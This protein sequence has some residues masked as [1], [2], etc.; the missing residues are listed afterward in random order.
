MSGV[1]GGIARRTSEKE[2]RKTIRK[3]MTNSNSSHRVGTPATSRRP[4]AWEMR[5][6]PPPY[7]VNTTGLEPCQESQTFSAR[8]MGRSPPRVVLGSVTRI[9]LPESI[10][11]R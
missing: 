5:T 1:Y 2:I 6:C 10:C 8:A 3:G 7:S 9:T 11:T 4:P